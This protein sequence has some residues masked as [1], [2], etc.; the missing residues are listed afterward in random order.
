MKTVLLFSK[1]MDSIALA[2]SKRPDL[3][4]TIDYGHRSAE[5]EIRAAQTVAGLLSLPLSIVRV[6]CGT[7]GSGDLAGTAP[8]AIAPASDWWPYRNQ[9]LVTIAASHAIGAKFEQ[10]MIATVRSDAAHA[11][12]RSD[13]I[14]ALDAVLQF[15]EGGLRLVAPAI[16][17]STTELVRSS[18]IDAS[19]L[20]WAHSCHR[21]PWSCGQCRGCNK[22]REVWQELGW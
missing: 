3:L 8:L 12:G 9:L 2:F 17:M 18:G 1:G 7:L 20:G 4:M 16:E 10:M 11:D 19:T 21:S 5:G 15:Q 14:E 13:F 22:C 6:D